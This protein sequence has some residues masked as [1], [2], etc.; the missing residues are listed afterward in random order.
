MSWFYKM[1]SMKKVVFVFFL[2][3]IIEAEAEELPVLL[4]HKLVERYRDSKREETNEWDEDEEHPTAADVTAAEVATRD[5]LLLPTWPQRRGRRR[6]RSWRSRSWRGWSWRG[7]AWG[8]AARRRCW[9]G[10]LV[11]ACDGLFVQ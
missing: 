6:S 4:D 8:A 10:P 9:K 1:I 3:V 2:G 5:V 11:L 7:G